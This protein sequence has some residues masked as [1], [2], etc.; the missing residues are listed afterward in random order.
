MLG[1]MMPKTTIDKDG[2]LFLM[3]NKIRRSENSL[4]ASP[5]SD[6]MPFHHVQQT[7]LGALIPRSPNSG[8]HH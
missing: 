1:A 3:K 7:Q 6:L 5:T 8:H 2:D 4:V